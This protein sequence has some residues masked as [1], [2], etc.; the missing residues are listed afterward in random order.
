MSKTDKICNVQ[1]CTICNNKLCVCL[2]VEARRF[3]SLSF[4]HKMML[5]GHC[6]HIFIQ[7][8]VVLIIFSLFTF[9]P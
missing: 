3:V 8:Y 9:R 4:F 6:F 2:N 1:I 7:N 5:H